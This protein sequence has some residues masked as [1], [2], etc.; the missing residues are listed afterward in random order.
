MA[1]HVMPSRLPGGFIG[2]DVFFVLSGFLI[3]SLIFEAVKAGKFSLREFYLRRAFRLGPNMVLMLGAVFLLGHC[4]ALPS[5]SRAASEHGLWVLG[6]VSNGYACTHLGGYW[7]GDATSAPLLHT[8]SLAVEEQFYFVYPLVL[9]GLLRFG[10]AR[11]WIGLIGLAAASWLA[12]WWATSHAPK[13]AFYLPHLRMWELLA[14]AGLA[15]RPVVGLSRRMSTALGLFG[16]CA[17]L[18]CFWLIKESSDFPGWMALIPTVGTV[19]LLAGFSQPE[20]RVTK[21][22]SHP[23]LVL[24]G[25]MSYSLYLW[26]WPAI[27]LTR[28]YAEIHDIGS[29]RSA[30]VVGGVVGAGL[31]WA[32]YRSV[33]TPIRTGE[34]RQPKPFTILA[35]GYASALILALTMRMPS[36]SHADARPIFAPLIFRGMEFSLTPETGAEAARSVRYRDV[37]FPSIKPPE[38]HAWRTGGIIKPHGATSSPQ[39]V[40]FGSSHALMYGGEIDDICRERCWPTAYFAADGLS[41]L[42]PTDECELLPTRELVQEYD[43]VRL[44]W[45]ARWQPRYLIVVDRW[46]RFGSLNE[47]DRRVRELLAA[48]QGKVGQVLFITQVP[49]LRLGEA[50]NLREFARWHYQRFARLPPISPDVRQNFRQ[51]QKN[52]LKQI[53]REHPRAKLLEPDS[54]FAQPDGSVRYVNGDKFLFADDDHL[55]QFGAKLLRPLLEEQFNE[56]T[57]PHVGEGV[58]RRSAAGTN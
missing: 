56:G 18:A 6:F 3:S 50:V 2:V 38:L 20:S 22:F 54:F 19:L 31:A 40:V 23:A 8:W 48:V 57:L 21:C 4:L 17:I 46:D 12:C 32:A 25:K 52:I 10:V 28:H 5:F 16:T 49:V 51:Q 36:H 53:V 33:E 13:E 24:V 55:S 43:R 45:L 34:I 11:T 41:A 27:V 47:F 35:V 30:S 37:E 58:S 44:E 7:G 14:G 26:H 9:V 15:L 42:F 1:F 39:V 29:R